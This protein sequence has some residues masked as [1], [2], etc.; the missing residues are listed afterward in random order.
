MGVVFKA[1]DLTLHR[2]V[3]LKFLPD[4]VAKDPQALARFQRE[5]QAAS[6]LNHPN[7]CT[8]HEIGQQDGR[9]FLV[10]EFLDGMTLKHRI[11]GK[12][13][14]IDLLLGV[15]IEIADALDAAH[16]EGIVHRDIKPGNIFLTKRGLAKIL[17]FGLAKVAPTA[18]SPCNMAS[19]NTVTATIDDQHLTSPSSTL[20]TVAYM[21]PEQARAKELDARSDLFSFG[22]VLYEMATG[23]LPFRGE[24]SAVIFKAI[25]D[26]AP[27][28]AVRLNADVPAELERI[29]NKALE[30]DRNLRYQHAGDIRT[31]LQRLK[32]DVESGRTAVPTAVPVPRVHQ[33]KWFLLAAAAVIFIGLATGGWLFYSGKAHA[34]SEK[35]TIV[36]ADFTNTTGDAVFDDALR[37]ALAADLAQSPFLNILSDARIRGALGL[38]G[39][40]ADERLT[41]EVTREL[42]VRT[43]GRAYLGGS[44]S[45]LG[46]SYALSVVAVNCQSGDTLAREQIQAASKEKVLD[47]L[48]QAAT[49]LRGELGESLRSIQKFDVPLEQVTTPSLEALQVYTLG[50]KTLRAKGPADGIPYFKRAIALDPNFASAYAL[51]GFAY[52]DLSETRLE[53]DYK[54]KAYALRDRTSGREKLFI[55]ATYHRGVTGDLTKEAETCELWKQ[56]YPRDPGPWGRLGTIDGL[57]GRFEKSVEEFRANLSL[58]PGGNQATAYGNLA[59]DNLYL[60]R[61]DDANAAAN[62]ASAQNP[63]EWDMRQVLYALAFLRGDA[64]TMTEQIAWSAVKPAAEP[65]LLFIESNTQAISGHLTKARELSRRGVELAERSDLKEEAADWGVMA[66][67]REAFFGNS[68][69]ARQGAQ[70]ALQISS[71]RDAEAIAALTLA[72]AGDPSQGQSLADALSKDYPSSTLVNAYWLPAIR[73]QIALDQGKPADAVELLQTASQYELGPVVGLV[74]YA[75]LYP[76]YVRGQAFLQLRQA[77]NAASEFQKYLDHRG[78]VWNCPLTPLAHLG[79]GR[80]YS[81]A[82]DQARARAAYQDFFVLWKDAD[83]D[84]PILKQA[85]VEYAK[86]Q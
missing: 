22:V 25:L 78:L 41:P 69:V 32:R 58:R 29:I 2:F 75:C 28:P 67:I 10:M 60:N 65:L 40:S 37:Q 79:L 57:L 86:L 85:K 54:K 8:I 14:E 17:D 45:T 53:S 38:M 80:A 82:G 62:A 12:P 5:A 42:C 1:E 66:A 34:L 47:A 48:D 46:S 76:V 71:G 64:K 43:Q 83:P 36:L 27:T 74:D 9:S 55:E 73:A 7:I 61:F 49:K 35:D 26:A 33:Y 44:I 24:S 6:A 52:G 4:D 84:I 18:N 56:T 20:G 15:A 39:R 72:A 59:Q 70:A 23:T 81:L 16:S 3:A 21:S 51:L 31:D 68:L 11:A 77:A 19:A 13:M 63:D 30:K 50:Q